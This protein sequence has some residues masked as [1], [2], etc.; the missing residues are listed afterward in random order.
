MGVVRES[1][2]PSKN[3]SLENVT[4]STE[5]M[6]ISDKENSV[7]MHEKRDKNITYFGFDESEGHNQ[8]NISPHKKF[9]KQRKRA[10]RPRSRAILQELNVQKQQ[11]GIPRF[12]SENG[13]KNKKTNVNNILND[14]VTESFPEKTD[15]CN[16]EIGN[17]INNA[18]ISD[19]ANI[20]QEDSQSVHLFEDLEVVHHVKPPRKS[21]V[22][23]KRVA[24][25]QNSVSSDSQDSDVIDNNASSAEEDDL[26]DLT[27]NIPMMKP[28]KT[29]N[30]KK[31]K[32]LLSKKE[33]KEVEAW[34]AG[35]NSM[36]ED[37]DEFD[38]VVE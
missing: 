23:Q 6:S 10:L 14:K 17:D 27:F 32:K 1:V 2:T 33:E 37:I 38:L 8:E 5:N 19:C 7:E 9:D 29:R 34:A 11:S 24:F 18:V 28:K 13:K 30:K 21:Y 20:S 16:S 15:D 12:I 25:R 22:K 31:S 3:K 26:Q 36:C 4:S 35:F